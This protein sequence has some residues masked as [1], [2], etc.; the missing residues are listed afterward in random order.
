MLEYTLINTTMGRRRVE[1]E[2]LLLPLTCIRGHG[3]WSKRCTSREKISFRQQREMDLGERI[4]S[5]L[6]T[7]GH[8]RKKREEREVEEE[9]NLLLLSLTHACVCA[10]AQGRGEKLKRGEGGRRR[11]EEKKGKGEEDERMR[12]GC[13]NILIRHDN[14]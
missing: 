9:K 10:G 14:T 4:C 6:L 8:T 11:G 1:G 12:R 3:E 13:D 2:D 7:H 5:P